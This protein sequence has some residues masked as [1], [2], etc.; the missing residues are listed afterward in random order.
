MSK[1]QDLPRAPVALGRHA[2]ELGS[3]Q[4]PGHRLRHLGPHRGM[5]VE[6]VREPC[7]NDPADH[8]LGQGLT[9]RDPAV[10][11][12]PRLLGPLFGRQS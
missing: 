12:L 3:F 2:R 5:A 9:E 10:G 6:K 8:S 7:E 1:R 4:H 11:R